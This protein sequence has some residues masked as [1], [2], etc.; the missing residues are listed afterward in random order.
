MSAPQ[1]S[2]KK[3]ADAIGIPLVHWQGNCFGVAKAINETLDL[4]GKVVWG[5]YIGK[6]TPLAFKFFGSKRPIKHGWIMWEDGLV[7]D[8]TRWIF[9][10]VQPYIYIGPADAYENGKAISWTVTPPKRVN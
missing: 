3:L 7:L 4:R 2:P 8:P 5:D 6:I 10:A 1:L 9:E